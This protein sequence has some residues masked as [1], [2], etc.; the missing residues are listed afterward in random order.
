MYFWTV[1]N[2][3]FTKVEIELLV[4]VNALPGGRMTDWRIDPFV[5]LE[6]QA[7]Q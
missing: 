1:E 2:V 5:F 4:G 6:A 7:G 3:F